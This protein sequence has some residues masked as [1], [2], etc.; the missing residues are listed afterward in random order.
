MQAKRAGVPY[1]PLKSPRRPAS[2]KVDHPTSGSP[3]GGRPFVPPSQSRPN[4]EESPQGQPDQG[5]EDD[6]YEDEDDI[7]LER[8]D[9]GEAR[10]KPKVI[11]AKVIDPPQGDRPSK[12]PAE[13]GAP[14]ASIVAERS[15]FSVTVRFMFD[16]W[17]VRYPN[18][19]G[20]FSEWVQEMLWVA[21]DWYGAEPA[22]LWRTPGSSPVTEVVRPFVTSEDMS[23]VFEAATEEVDVAP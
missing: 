19:K 15:S 20:T 21:W 7:D 23:P 3:A 18:Y 9:A 13:W 14:D 6:I 4:P 22:V 10:S 1:T 16:G 12:P 8:G 17:R 11:D 2:P 5:D